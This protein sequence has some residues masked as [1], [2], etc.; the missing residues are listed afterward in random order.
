MLFRSVFFRNARMDGVFFSQKRRF[1]F[2]GVGAGVRQGFCRRCGRRNRERPD[3]GPQ[4]FHR[5]IR[6]VRQAGRTQK[7][8]AGEQC[9]M[10]FEVFRPDWARR[11]SETKFGIFAKSAYL[12]LK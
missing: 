11:R 3:F 4:A 12:A 6:S 10:D 9:G 2:H 7:I 8:A 5:S 1:S